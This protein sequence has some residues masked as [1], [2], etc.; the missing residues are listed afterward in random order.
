MEGRLI[1][2]ISLVTGAGSGIGRATAIAFAREGAKVAVV[3]VD[4]EGGKETVT[5]IKESGGD[6]IF[7]KTSVAEADE[8]ES[9]VNEVV[10]AYGRLD[11][12]FNNAAVGS[13]GVST[14]E[15]TLENW[16]HALN[17][18]LTGVWLCMKYEIT[19]MLKQGKGAIVNTSSGAGLNGY[20]GGAAY[21]A[22][23]HGVIGLTKTAALEYIQQGIR[24]NAVCPGV[25]HTPMVER[26][27]NRS[28]GIEARFIAQMPIGR[29]GRPE[30]IAEAV[31]WLSTD[32]AS[33]VTGLAMSVDGG[34]SAQS[35]GPVMTK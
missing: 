10:R 15:H 34:L 26:A 8:V 33:L 2:K 21:S 1:G 4:V 13:A 28:P 5:K 7:M 20:R 35:I 6:S 27:M 14:H 29:L 3:D 9:M 22:S 31:I 18:N 11:C 32:A 17:V 24:I 30:E 12:A 23:K 19:Q 25:T 16:L